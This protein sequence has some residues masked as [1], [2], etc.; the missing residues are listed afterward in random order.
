MRDTAERVGAHVLL[1]SSTCRYESCCLLVTPTECQAGRRTRVAHRMHFPLLQPVLVFDGP[2]RERQRNTCPDMRTGNRRS[3]PRPHVR[4]GF[5][6]KHAAH[7]EVV[8][9]RRFHVTTCRLQEP[10]FAASQVMACVPLQFIPSPMCDHMSRHR[11]SPV[12]GLLSSCVLFRTAASGTGRVVNS[13]PAVRQ[14]AVED[15]PAVAPA[16]T[17]AVAPAVAP[18]NEPEPRPDEGETAAGGS[19]AERPR[20]SQ[21]KAVLCSRRLSRSQTSA[22]GRTALLSGVLGSP[23]S[24][25][26][27]KY[28]AVA[29]RTEAVM[30]R[31]VV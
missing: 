4:S 19:D 29:Q 20:A 7:D 1:I 15:T 18:A 25:S 17:P 10:F 24:R 2:P 6:S 22:A 26:A 14:L 5:L 8:A 23:W 9:F 28:G 31:F 12:T 30:H 27:A 3:P 11:L 13:P 16:I 21:K